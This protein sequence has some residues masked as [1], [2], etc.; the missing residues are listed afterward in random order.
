MNIKEILQ[1]LKVT[2]EN[3]F[4]AL[5]QSLKAHTYTARLESNKV[6]VTN[7]LVLPKVIQVEEIKQVDNKKTI[8][9]QT[10][11]YIKALNAEVSRLNKTLL[12][13]SPHKTVEVTNLK[14]IPK[15][16]SA[17]K[18][19]NPQKSIS[20]NNF[21]E[22]QTSIGKLQKAVEALKLDPKIVVPDIKVPDVYV[23]EIKI[24]T[25]K[26]EV[27]LDKLEKL[28]GDDAKKYV[29][30]R[31]TDGKK[32]Y[33]ALEELNQTIS[34]GGS[35]SYAYQ[36]GAGD[37]TYALVNTHRQAE[38]VTATFE[39]N[40]IDKTSTTGVRYLCAENKFGEWF[41]TKIDNSGSNPE[42]GYASIINNPTY[43]TYTLAYADRTILTYDNYSQVF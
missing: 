42:F 2:I 27:N 5:A 21:Y 16:L 19:S 25:I 22:L 39:L 7:P 31:L 11:K 13:L 24:P 20:V 37:H 12:T 23:P 17:I 38:V 6:E 26:N 8:E 43:L 29:P 4:I 14:D 10:S 18:V 32:F 28:I 15:P 9:E 36:D 30:V 3:N 35:R 40:N 34:G 1:F 33:Q 41:F